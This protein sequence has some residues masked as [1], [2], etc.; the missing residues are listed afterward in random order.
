MCLLFGLRCCLVIG[1]NKARGCFTNTDPLID[2]F[3]EHWIFGYGF[4][5]FVGPLKTTSQ[6]QRDKSSLEVRQRL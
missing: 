2:S 6:A 4:K 5:E 1:P 3:Y